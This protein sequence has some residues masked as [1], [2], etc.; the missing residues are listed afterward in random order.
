M[1]TK[2]IKRLR[3]SEQR[4]S[5]RLEQTKEDIEVAVSEAVAVATHKVTTATQNQLT[6]QQAVVDKTETAASAQLNKLHSK[7]STLKDSN[8]AASTKFQQQ[9]SNLKQ[10][11]RSEVEE[12]NLKHESNINKVQHQNMLQLSRK[13]K[14]YNRQLKSIKTAQTLALSRLQK[15][16]N[17]NIASLTEELQHEKK[18]K[19]KALLTSKSKDY[20]ELREVK[21]AN[22]RLETQ[23]EKKEK[24]NK[25][26]Q[27]K[28]SDAKNK[29]DTLL[30][31]V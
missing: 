31:Q 19:R 7:I 17:T 3:I 5:S 25:E 21:R 10:K 29:Y 16:Y 8:L 28:L 20:I 6:E 12:L 2:T 13:A 22:V 1:A 27:C 30:A 9:L 18:E 26:E 24:I 4:L 11:H 14:G 15:E 23:L